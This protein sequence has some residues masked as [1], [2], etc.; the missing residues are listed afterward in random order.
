MS[1]LGHEDSTHTDGR[2][3]QWREEKHG[4]AG[5]NQR[6]DSQPQIHTFDTPF[7]DREAPQPFPKDGVSKDL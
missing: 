2:R 6:K 5:L 4:A 1:R 7:H 3:S